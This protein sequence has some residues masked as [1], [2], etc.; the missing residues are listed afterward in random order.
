MSTAS[1]KC[2]F[3]AK[4][5]LKNP[6]CFQ[7]TSKASE[8][9]VSE[10]EFQ[11]N[12]FFCK[13]ICLTSLVRRNPLAL[14]GVAPLRVSSFLGEPFVRCFGMDFDAFSKPSG[15][16]LGKSLIDHWLRLVHSIKSLNDL[17]DTTTNRSNFHHPL[18]MVI[19]FH[20]QNCN[21]NQSTLIWWSFWWFLRTRGP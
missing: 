13:L 14:S 15:Y 3:R 2:D 8:M 16:L 9:Q 20:P 19:M 17:E 12:W 7:L 21:Q 4:R 1:Q 5:L 11:S 18:E 10:F 6:T